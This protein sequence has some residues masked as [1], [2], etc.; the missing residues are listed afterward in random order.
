MTLN[1][2]LR[3]G[4]MLLSTLFFSCFY[5]PASS[6]EPADPQLRRE[7]EIGRKAVEQ[8]E[9]RWELVA[10]PA[11]L[12]HLAMIADRLKPHLERDISYEVRIIRSD[13][14][15]AFC[16]PGGFI[17][18]TSRMLERLRSD[19]E[20]AAVMAHEMI[21][22][23]RAHGVQM[24]A[25]A[26][27]VNLAAL[28]AM[29]LS[30]GAVAPIV[31]AQ[32]AQVAINSA[33]TIEFEKEADSMGLD[34]LIAA[35]YPPSAMVTL[36]EGFMHE[37]MKQPIREYGIYMNHPE[38][39][40]RVQSLSEKLKSMSISVERKVPLQLLR[41]S[42][43]EDG[44]SAR[45]LIDGTEVW[46]GRQDESTLELLEQVRKL[47]DRD[48]QMELA[49][50]DLQLEGDGNQSLLRLK[51]NV[52]AKTPLPEG[53]PDLAALR[54]NLLAALARAQSRHP[55]AKYFR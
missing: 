21:H 45:L 47:L 53:M 5:P 9:A 22:V 39:V 25:K 35:G 55:I 44:E 1:N 28:A 24:A 40:E 51:N 3:T 41:T 43:A 38:S 23:D 7:T 17:F 30:G 4:A 14:A 54:G 42:I 33:Y 12:V 6:A 20:I 29:V 49:P 32:V 36:M 19:A 27:R 31:L 13:A 15:N 11:R 52:L 48:F 8:I 34:L 50:Y 2:R 16:L 18:F 26:N 10:D 46:G 37:E